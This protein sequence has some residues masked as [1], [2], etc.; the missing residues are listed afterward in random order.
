MLPALTVGVIGTD[1]GFTVVVDELVEVDVEVVE[2]VVA[3]EVVVPPP[4]VVV[5]AVDVT[6][7]VVVDEPW[8]WT[9]PN[10]WEGMVPDG[11]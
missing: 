3:V 6:V 7:V 10:D 9:G 5:G 1:S 8:V 2:V 4:M 11:G